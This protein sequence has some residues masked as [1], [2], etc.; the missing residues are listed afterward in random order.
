MPRLF[1]RGVTVPGREGNLILSVYND[2][3]GRLA[4][5]RVRDTVGQLGLAYHG[6][7]G[8][9]LAGLGLEL[10]GRVDEALP[11]RYALIET[12]PG[13]EMATVRELLRFDCDRRRSGEGDGI[14]YI[15][16]N[17][18]CRYSL[19][20]IIGSNYDLRTSG[21]RHDD[22]CDLLKV[23]DAHGNNI[24]GSGVKVAVVDSGIEKVGA[25]AAFRDVWDRQNRTE[26]DRI[27]H[28]TAMTAIVSD[29]APEASVYSVRIS[30]GSR[31][32]LW[33][34]MLGVSAA[35][36]EFDADIISLSLGLSTSI[37][38]PACKQAVSHCPNCGWELPAIS[39]TLE[40]F[41]GGI[42]AVD[43][44]RTGAP[45]IVSATGNKGQS[46]VDR[47]AAYDL[48]MAVG[49]I[50]ESTARSAFSNYSAPHARFI[51]MP[52][53]DEDGQQQP[54][55]WIGEGSQAKCLGTSPATAYAAGMLALYLS[56]TTYRDAD[57]SVFLN[58]V[59]ANCRKCVN[60]SVSEQGKGYLPYVP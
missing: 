5:M 30:E 53:G 51:V 42:V 32:Q 10:A 31:P 37:R 3:A 2:E 17:L 8:E 34:A 21:S 39:K 49:A 45:M 25:A 9:N 46:G 41:L 14:A 47:P 43:A 13:Y 33:N 16:P 1:P 4:L 36:F 40:S 57:R 44:G 55:E 52:G 56:D 6:T 50:N 15:E 12:M 58:N 35:S 29:I 23:D 24:K 19:P 38:C 60:H 59:L 20:G 26:A 18:E 28:G 48:A 54:T 7:L 11:L 27:G 22:Y